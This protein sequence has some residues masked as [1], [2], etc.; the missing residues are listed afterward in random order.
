MIGQCFPG[1]GEGP[2]AGSRL[3]C[4]RNLKGMVG[5]SEVLELGWETEPDQGS[6]RGHGFV[7]I[8]T[9]IYL[10]TLSTGVVGFSLYW[11]KITLAAVGRMTSAGQEWSKSGNRHFRKVFKLDR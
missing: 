11:K 10:R 3:A 5:L 8:A 1:R 7:V 4:S 2:G 9:G 6:L